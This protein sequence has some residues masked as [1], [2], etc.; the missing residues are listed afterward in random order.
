MLEVDE[1]ERLE[2]VR[3]QDSGIDLEEEIDGREST[4][5][6]IG[7]TYSS[8]VGNEGIHFSL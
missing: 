3:V 4:D 6:E 5:K 1:S 7:Q 2:V 8:L